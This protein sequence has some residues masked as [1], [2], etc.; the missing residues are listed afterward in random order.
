MYIFPLQTPLQTPI[1]T[2]LPG[3]TDNSMYQNIATP[4]EYTNVHDTGGATTELKPG[5]PSPYM[6]SPDTAFPF[7]DS[8]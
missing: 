2:P 8:G 4:S 7:L 3:T 5:R 1:Q 6:V